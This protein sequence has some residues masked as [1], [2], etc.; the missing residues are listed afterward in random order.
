MAAKRSTSLYQPKT[1]GRHIY[2]TTKSMN[3]FTAHAV[4]PYYSK[5]K[6]FDT[7]EE[8]KQWIDWFLGDLPTVP[9]SV[10]NHN[11]RYYE[12]LIKLNPGSNVL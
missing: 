4:T 9:E 3:R 8:C 6:V 7:I 11:I 1:K 2:R 10:D 12:M 5:S